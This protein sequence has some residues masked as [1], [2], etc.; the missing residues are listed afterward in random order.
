MNKK[1]VTAE[2]VMTKALNKAGV[3]PQGKLWLEHVLDPFKDLPVACEGFPD[4]NMNNSVI[5]VVKSSK[6]IATTSGTNT[7]DV[8]IFTDTSSVSS[9]LYATNSALG[10]CFQHAAQSATVTLRGGIVIR[11]DVSGN[12]LTQAKTTANVPLLD[13]YF[14][15]RNSRV[16]AQGFEVH[17]NTADLYKQGSVCTWRTCADPTAFVSTLIEDDGTTACIPTALMTIKPPDVP[18]TLAECMLL[19]GSTQWDAEKGVYVVPVMISEENEPVALNPILT[20]VTDSSGEFINQINTTGAAKK[21][22]SNGKACPCVFSMSGAMF[23]GLS[24]QT[25]L[26]LNTV[27]IIEEFPDK[28]D[29]DLNTL[30]R[31]SAP[32]DPR[33]LAIYSKIA[34]RLPTGVEVRLNG[35]GDWVA[36]IASFISEAAKY[37]GPV[38]STIAEVSSRVAREEMEQRDHFYQSMAPMLT[39]RVSNRPRA[40][41]VTVEEVNVGSRRNPVIEE[42]IVSRSKPLPPIPSRRSKPLPNPPNTMRTAEMKN[43]VQNTNSWNNNN[44]NRNSSRRKR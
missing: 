5:A 24:P 40:E 3:T 9:N 34:K 36:G 32:F 26:T 7:W 1:I 41:T 13:A 23:T 35:L 33:V 16:I 31:P 28:D 10:S 21:I 18:L 2:N 6:T 30:A 17:N 19:P 22:S 43:S 12:A 29:Q 11:Q 20:Y 25:I 15:N 38:A 4:T 8:S 44:S 37:V 27:F 39:Q 14:Q 42:Q